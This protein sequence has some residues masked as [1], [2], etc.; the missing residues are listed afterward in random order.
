MNLSYLVSSIKQLP[1]SP[2]ILPKLQKLLGNG[3][4]SLQEITKLIRLDPAL[5]T[6]IIRISNSVYY[7]GAI[8]CVSIDDAVNR[9]GLNEVFK[10][11]GMIVARKMFGNTLTIYSS[12]A[13]RLWE[14]SVF[15]GMLMFELAES[16]GM[17]KELAYT[18]G[19]LHSI[20]KVVINNYHHEHG[21]P[22]YIERIGEMNTEWEMRL[23]GFN[24]AEVS[25]ALLRRWGFDDVIKIPIEYQFKPYLVN[26]VHQKMT[27]L[28]YAVK[29]VCLRC[30][31]EDTLSKE[32]LNLDKD[33]SDVLNVVSV[34]FIIEKTLHVQKQ[35]A[36][37]KESI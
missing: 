13:G 37:L 5:T 25:T 17:D 29:L 14:T 35:L 28:L 1:P 16:V 6:Q 10:L 21:I 33:I 18:T 4:A 23:L 8:A 30:E 36:R 22:G 7:G 24:N 32:T 3:D 31:M 15:C 34:E 20:G 12:E 11:I 2:E 9:V 26:T 27:Y 19:L